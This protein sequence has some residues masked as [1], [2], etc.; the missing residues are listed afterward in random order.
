MM[1]VRRRPTGNIG[2]GPANGNRFLCREDLFHFFSPGVEKCFFL[3]FGSNGC[4]VLAMGIREELYDPA[5]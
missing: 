5:G 1:Q 3:A 4:P 2:G